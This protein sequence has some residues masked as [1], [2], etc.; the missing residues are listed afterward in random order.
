MVV[1]SA[2]IFVTG[3]QKTLEMGE[4]AIKLQINI[5]GHRKVKIPPNDV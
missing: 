2:A 5:V 4:E 1:V 3:H